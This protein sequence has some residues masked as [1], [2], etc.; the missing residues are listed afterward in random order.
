[1]TVVILILFGK[2]SNTILQCILFI[3]RPCNAYNEIIPKL[4]N[5]TTEPFAFIQAVREHD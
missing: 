2:I 3:T 4:R 5:L 1:M